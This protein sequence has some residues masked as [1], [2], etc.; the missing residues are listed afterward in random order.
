M[1]APPKDP[2]LSRIRVSATSSGTYTT[3]LMARGYTH[4]SGTANGTTMYWLGGE[5]NRA[6]DP[7]ESGTIPAF[8]DR[9]D[10]LGQVLLR[11]SRD[12]GTTVWLQLCPEGTATGAKVDQFEANIT[13][14]TQVVD[15]GNDGIEQTFTY[16]GVGGT[17]TEVTLA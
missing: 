14:Y 16:S 1:A 8:F 9:A 13:A 15:V 11:A 4:E 12:N 10:T 3:I 17:K 2:K 7:T 6:G 5:A